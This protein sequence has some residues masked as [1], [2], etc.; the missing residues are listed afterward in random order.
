MSAPR[1]LLVVAA[2]GVLVLA[3]L[4]GLRGRFSERVVVMFVSWIQ[5]CVHDVLAARGKNAEKVAATLAI[6]ERLPALAARYGLVYA[7]WNAICDAQTRQTGSIF[8]RF[9]LYVDHG[10]PSRMGHALAAQRVH[11]ALARP[12]AATRAAAE[13]PAGR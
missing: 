11:Q 6:L 2:A 3:G 13:P 8:A 12:P 7:D 9:G 1:R 4:A 5:V 10:H